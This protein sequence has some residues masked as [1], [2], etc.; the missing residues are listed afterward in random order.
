MGK[1]E[2]TAVDST[3]RRLPIKFYVCVRGTT[4]F[5]CECESVFCRSFESC[6]YS[7]LKKW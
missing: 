2:T 1:T 3:Q 4:D 6:I 5:T 7:S